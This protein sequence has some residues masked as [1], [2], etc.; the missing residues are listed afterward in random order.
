M[1]ITIIAEAKSEAYYTSIF[2]LEREGKA[3]KINFFG[4]KDFI[5][6]PWLVFRMLYDVIKA[7]VTVLG[8][9][10][11]N[12][13]IPL[14]LLLGALN[15]RF[16]LFTSWN[17]W[18]SPEIYK[19]KF[20]FLTGPWK[21][22][23]KGSQIV[24]VTDEVK[25]SL[26]EWNPDISADNV[27]VINH[28]YDDNLYRY[29][30]SD[31]REDG[32]LNLVQVARFVEVKGILETIEVVKKFKASEIHFEIFGH[33][34]LS[35]EILAEIEG[36]ERFTY[37]GSG[38]DLDKKAE[39]YGRSDYIILGS[40]EEKFGLVTVEA[41][42]CGTPM[43]VSKTVGQSDIVDRVNSDLN[44]VF[45]IGDWGQLEKILRSLISSDRPSAEDRKKLSEKV[46]Q[47]YS[48]KHLSK[49][50]LKALSRAI[51]TS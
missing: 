43:L 23:T 41:M 31:P 40:Y 4:P 2:Q 12:P 46:E 25:T 39:I 26:I 8:F 24:A 7:D 35:D 45:E 15:K 13:T 38:A 3:S 51:S 30:L 28:A 20:H 14:F 17:E 36:D 42:A 49:R 10:P 33:G 27:H 50:W 22:F 34:K 18:S 11:L 48:P 44:R 19:W 21:R 32:K 29:E 37:Q 47:L 9:A 1:I 5:W 16:V 6:R